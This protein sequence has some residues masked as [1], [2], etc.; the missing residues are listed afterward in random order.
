MCE[1]NFYFWIIGKIGGWIWEIIIYGW[2]WKVCWFDKIN[3]KFKVNLYFDDEL[4]F[5]ICE[6]FFNFK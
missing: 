3:K 4:M 6:F 2:N 5:E 1:D